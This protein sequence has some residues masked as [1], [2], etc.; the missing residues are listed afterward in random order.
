SEGTDQGSHNEA[1][2]ETQEAA[3]C[4]IL[5]EVQK[6]SK[7]ARGSRGARGAREIGTAGACPIRTPGVERYQDLI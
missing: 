2:D 6:G 1:D 7:G 5:V 3:H 4:A